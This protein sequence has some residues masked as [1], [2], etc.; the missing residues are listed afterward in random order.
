MQKSRLLS[1]LLWPV[2]TVGIAAYALGPLLSNQF[3]S[4]KPVTD[5]TAAVDFTL[6]TLEGESWSL[7]DQRGKVV[8]VNFWATWCPPCRMETPDLV[9]THGKYENRGFTVVG[10]TLDETPDEDVPPFVERYG[11]QYPILL[12]SAE[13][14]GNITSLPTS[15]L[16][17]RN[18]RVAKTYRGIVT[19]SALARDVEALLKERS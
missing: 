14:G 13:V 10:V 12:P 19:E 1:K 4:V 2:L 18:G 16:I 5:R 7:A 17:D 8:L 15:L 6:S 3:G 11:M 9:A